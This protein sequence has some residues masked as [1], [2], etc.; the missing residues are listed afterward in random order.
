M[1]DFYT[2]KWLGFSGQGHNHGNSGGPLIDTADGKVLGIVTRKATV[3]TKDF[4]DLDTVLQSNIKLLN[5]SAGGVFLSGVDSIS[6]TRMIQEQIRVI[7][8]NIGRSANVG[9]GYANHIS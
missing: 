2:F 9:I 3:L 8:R 4:E 1:P 5:Q 6:A 7:C